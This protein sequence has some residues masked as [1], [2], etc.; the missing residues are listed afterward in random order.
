MSGVPH[1]WGEE[2]FVN[3]YDGPQVGYGL[4]SQQYQP[5]YTGYKI[6]KCA[7]CGSIRQRRLLD[8]P[9]SLKMNQIHRDDS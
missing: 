9:L 8:S 4:P 3:Q 5:T 1:S 6:Q 2:K 7:V